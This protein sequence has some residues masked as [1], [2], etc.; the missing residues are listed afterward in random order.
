MTTI[1]R[2][3]THAT[4]RPDGHSLVVFGAGELVASDDPRAQNGFVTIALANGWAER[5]HA[6]EGSP[7]TPRSASITA[8]SAPS[9]K[10]KAF[11]E[12]TK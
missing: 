7:V 2:M 5:L 6:D 4:W 8:R 10:A 11:V 3:L 12:R 9:R 1:V